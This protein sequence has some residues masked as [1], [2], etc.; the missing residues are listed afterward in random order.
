MNP[1]I[2]AM[3]LFSQPLKFSK[4]VKTKRP[5]CF[6]WAFERTATV[7]TNIEVREVHTDALVLIG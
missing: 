4:S 5:D 7:M 6:G 1:V 2:K 3:T